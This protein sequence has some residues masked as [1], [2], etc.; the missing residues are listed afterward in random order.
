MRARAHTLARCCVQRRDARHNARACSALAFEGEYTR[1]STQ[2]VLSLSRARLSR[3]FV[4]SSARRSRTHTYTH[5]HVCGISSRRCGRHRY[6]PAPG[7]NIIACRDKFIAGV[8][9]PLAN[10]PPRSRR[11]T[12][13]RKGRRDAGTEGPRS[14]KGRKG[15]RETVDPRADPWIR[16]FEGYISDDRYNEIY[17]RDAPGDNSDRASANI[18]HAGRDV[19]AEKLSRGD[20]ARKCAPHANLFRRKRIISQAVIPPFTIAL[21]PAIPRRH[22]TIIRPRE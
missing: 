22:S 19:T 18:M 21:L 20:V 13:G 3:A 10:V 6:I 17:I 7:T 2:A 14:G 16:P 11:K 4:P 1:R 12:D 15:G 8:P 9:Q 5:T